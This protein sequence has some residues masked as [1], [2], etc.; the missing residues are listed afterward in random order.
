M[1][2]QNNINSTESFVEAVSC[3]L[4]DARR[5]QEVIQLHWK[6]QQRLSSPAWPSTQNLIGKISMYEKMLVNQITI[7][8]DLEKR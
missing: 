7:I 3:E 8:T 5:L 1:D 4:K 6:L 2:V